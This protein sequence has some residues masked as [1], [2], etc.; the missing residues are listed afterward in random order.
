MNEQQTASFDEKK[1]KI[2]KARVDENLAVRRLN[3]MMTIKNN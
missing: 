1:K 3:N 2:E